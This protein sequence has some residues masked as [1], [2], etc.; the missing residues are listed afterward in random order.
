MNTIRKILAVMVIAALFVSGTVLAEEVSTITAH[1]YL[2]EWVD[3]DGTTNID[4]E[5]REEGNG[6]IATVHHDV[7][8]EDTFTYIEWAYACVYDEETQTMKCFS[9]VTGNGDYEPDSE[10]EIVDVDFD[11]EEGKLVFSQGSGDIPAPRKRD[12]IAQEA[13]LLLRDYNLGHASVPSGGLAS[14]GASD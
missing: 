2:G 3:Q 9:R 1:D 12:T 7:L 6:Y 8:S 14:G 11:E 5:A 4:V 13:E 10:D